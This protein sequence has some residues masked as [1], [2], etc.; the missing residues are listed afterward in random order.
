MRGRLSI[1]AAASAAALLY[2]AAPAAAA[3]T[4]EGFCTA[5]GTITFLKPIGNQPRQ[6]AFTDH[7]E[8]VCTGT[9]NGQSGTERIKLDA[10]GSGMMGCAAT[11]STDHGVITFTRNTPTTRDD[12]H[13]RY[14]AEARGGL[15]QIVARVRGAISGESISHVNFLPYGSQQQIDQCNAG[16]L[17]SV[18]YDL[19]SQTLTPLVG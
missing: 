2:S 5:T 14:I 1:I 7:A 18:R 6:T 19:E 8:G 15:T 17:R 13:L 12:L 16:T 3:N 4:A 11:L 10:V 9:V